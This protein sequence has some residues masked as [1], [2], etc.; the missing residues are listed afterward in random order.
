[1]IA[2]LDQVEQQYLTL[3]MASVIINVDG[4]KY[5][6]GNIYPVSKSL[7]ATAN[8]VNSLGRGG[9]L[10]TQ[11]NGGEHNSYLLD[12]EMSQHS[13]DLMLTS[14]YNQTQAYQPSSMAHY[15]KQ[16]LHRKTREL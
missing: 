11:K 13:P 5:N 1:M 16:R 14:N 6:E 2:M 4:N 10:S 3:D 9:N 7:R 12:L 8:K 15:M